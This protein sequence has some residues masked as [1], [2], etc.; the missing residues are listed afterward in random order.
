MSA[1]IS[2]A[3][4]GAAQSPVNH[5]G[6]ASS[7]LLLAGKSVKRPSSM[8]K[9]CE[10]Y[11]GP[12]GPRCAVCVVKPRIRTCLTNCRDYRFDYL[13]MISVEILLVQNT[14]KIRGE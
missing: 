9:S 13:S 14:I 2:L 6:K 12:R 7:G 10:Y 3:S 11:S 4:R 5:R 1:K 8:S